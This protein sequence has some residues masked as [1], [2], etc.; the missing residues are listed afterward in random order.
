M[1]IDYK[2]FS[3]IPVLLLIIGAIILVDG[4]T[5]TGDWFLRSIDLK[6][7]T[8]IS[9]KGVSVTEE[10]IPGF[11]ARIRSFGGFGGEGVLIEVSTDVKAEDV[12][13]ALER[14]GISVKDASIQTIGPALGETFWRQTQIGIVLAFIMMGIVVFFLFRKIVPSFAVIFAA[15]ADILVT[16]AFMQVFGIPFS[17]AGLAAILML[18][19][20][21]VDTDILLTS[22]MLRGSGPLGE[23]LRYALKTGL[24]MSLT[25]MT[26]LVI[27]LVS[28]VSPVITQIASVLL[29]GLVLDLVNTWFMNAVILRWYMERRSF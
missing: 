9:I 1:K 20:Y 3:I 8:L 23:R 18:I 17:L 21:S 14:K 15:V 11:D 6:G 22:R 12:L 16:L 13:D 28:G 19:G 29:I 7:G 27:L 24:T 4:Y 5:K 10:D 26:V 25:T 2:L